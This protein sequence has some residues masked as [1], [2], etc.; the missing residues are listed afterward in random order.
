MK[1][2]REIYQLACR[3]LD[4]DPGRAAF[5]GDGCSNELSGAAEAGLTPYWA[6]W[7]VDCWP[8]WRQNR[9]V[10][11]QARKWPRLKSPGDVV[12]ILDSET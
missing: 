10:Y 2:N 5:I 1:P 3:E 9:D 6:S 8:E 12:A 7:F 4:V 11:V